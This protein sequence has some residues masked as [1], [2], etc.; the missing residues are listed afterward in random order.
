M[1]LS[2][3]ISLIVG[4]SFNNLSTNEVSYKESDAQDRSFFDSEWLIAI[5]V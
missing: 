5:P 1:L 3:G 2:G 4:P